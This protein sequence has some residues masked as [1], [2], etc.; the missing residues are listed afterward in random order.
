MEVG[1][2]YKCVNRK[3]QIWWTQWDHIDNYSRENKKKQH[4]LAVEEKKRRRKNGAQWFKT[5][6]MHSR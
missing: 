3:N 1:K 2:W 6:L 4:F 5:D